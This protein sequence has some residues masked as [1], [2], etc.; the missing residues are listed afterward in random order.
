MLAFFHVASRFF[1]IALLTSIKGSWA[2][3]YLCGDMAVYLTYRAVL[4]LASLIGFFK[5]IDKDYLHTFFDLASAKQH[6]VREFCNATNNFESMQV[7][8]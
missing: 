6:A 3:L 8:G 7:F 5:S 1:A 2:A 4:W